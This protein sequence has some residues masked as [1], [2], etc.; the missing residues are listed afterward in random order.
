MTKRVRIENAD[1]TDHKVLVQLWDKGQDG[2]PDTLAEEL[3]LDY[4][5]ALLDL[6]VWANRYIVVKEG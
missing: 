1:T 5:T 4:P 2:A 3:N 6:C